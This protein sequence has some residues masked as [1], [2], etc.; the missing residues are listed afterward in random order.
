M[1]K[2]MTKLHTGFLSP[3][4]E[5]YPCDYMEH[6]TVAK[7]ILETLYPDEWFIDPEDILR[8]NGWVDIHKS[9]PTKQYSF[10]WDPR[11]NLTPEQKHIIRPI[12]EENTGDISSNSMYL[13]MCEFNN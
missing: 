6:M 11:G 4:G 2:R 8:R 5:F 7:E 1:T 13:L 9:L 3:T 12:V 10:Y